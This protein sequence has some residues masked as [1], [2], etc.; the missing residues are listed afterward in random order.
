MVVL[1]VAALLWFFVIGFGAEVLAR[2]FVVVMRPR[3][4]TRANARMDVAYQ[5]ELLAVDATVSEAPQPPP[6]VYVTRA[7]P[8][9]TLQGF[10]SLPEAV[11]EQLAAEWRALV[12]VCTR[13]GIATAVC[14]G[15]APDTLRAL[16]ETIRPA[17]SVA[18]RFPK[19]V[20]LDVESV[21]R[22]PLGVGESIQRDFP[23]PLPHGGVPIFEFSFS[24]SQ[25]GRE[26]LIA[27]RDSIWQ[28][29]WFKFSPYAY[30]DH[31][32]GNWVF[33][34]NSLGFRD[35]EIVLPKPPGVYR[36]VCVGGSTTFEGPRND[37]TYPK[38]LQKRLREYFGTDKI[39]VINC[40]VNALGSA[41]ERKR[42]ADYLALQPDLLVDYNFVNNV[43][44][45]LGG[46]TRPLTFEAAPLR[47]MSQ[48][49]RKSA[50]LALF[51]SELLVPTDAVL[52]GAIE[53][54]PLQDLRTML[55]ETRKAGVA[56]AECSIA[57]P[58]GLQ[59]REF[60]PIFNK[61]Y[62]GAPDFE[63]YAK[64][65]RLYNALLKKWCDTEGV[66]YL[67]VAEGFA[68]R[69]DDFRDDCHMYLEGISQKA[70][71]VFEHL[72]SRV[73]QAIGRND[74]S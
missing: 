32:C 10:A 20:A 56:M 24:S 34:I 5:K 61:Q 13:E 36:I 12:V 48:V 69:G 53:R 27:I 50:F 17:T 60:E 15:N 1:V 66:L 11:R 43:G 74:E 58:D 8:N 45:L 25:N 35:E 49:L 67:P 72:K 71:I 70:D 16:K 26:T 4:E 55:C 57:C 7:I 22:T 42:L 46:I 54:G 33:W 37:L 14:G 3:I 21:L 41:D 23:I 31:F 62:L 38:M 47:A 64:A 39:E 59:K 28:E 63:S 68:G 29:L 73:A 2:V 19:P 65:F 44:G 52:T 18:A 9:D 40:G 30:R 51:A 6:Q